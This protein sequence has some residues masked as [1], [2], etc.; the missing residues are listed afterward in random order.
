MPQYRCH[1]CDHGYPNFLDGNKANE[2]LQV[3]K[4]TDA[5]VLGFFM[6]IDRQNWTHA[7]CC[8]MRATT[9]EDLLKA[10]AKAVFRDHETLILCLLQ[11]E[12]RKYFIDELITY[13]CDFI[14]YTSTSTGSLMFYIREFVH[15]E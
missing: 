8:G 11:M 4:I 6:I 10:D 1:F 3:P 9:H 5:K 2:N 12:D 7:L 15:V 13:H 14:K